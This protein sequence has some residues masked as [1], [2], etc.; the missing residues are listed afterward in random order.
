MQPEF[1]EIG[2]TGAKVTFTAGI[3]ALFVSAADGQGVDRDDRVL[4]LLARLMRSLRLLL[5]ALD[6]DGYASYTVAREVTSRAIALRHAVLEDDLGSFQRPRS[7]TLASFKTFAQ[8]T[9]ASGEC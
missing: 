1:Q 8:Y 2:H 3:C 9:I 5:P 4:E 6:N 7:S